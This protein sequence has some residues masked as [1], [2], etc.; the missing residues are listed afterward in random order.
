MAENDVQMIDEL[1]AR[2]DHFIWGNVLQK[3]GPPG[4]LAAAVLRYVYALLR[5]I[6]S[7]QLTLRAMSLVYTTLLSI[8]PLIA[9]SF[10]VLKGLGVHNDLR[11]ILDNLLLPLGDQGT[12]ISNQVFTL[13]DNVRG[14]ILGGVSLAFFIFTAISMVQKVEASFNYVWHVSKPRSFARRF[15]E[16]TIVLLIGPVVIVVALGMIASIQNNNLVQWLLTNESLGAVVL[17]VGKI[18]PYLLV[19][20]VFTFLYIFVPN[21][22]VRFKSALV[23][24]FAGGIIWASMSAVFATFVV[25]AGTRQLIY[26]GF[27]VAITALI[28][29][30]LNWLVLLVGAQLAFYHQR[31]AFLRIGQREPRLSN[32]MRERLALNSMYLVGRA[33]RHRDRSI[34]LD[35]IGRHLKIPVNALSQVTSRLAEAGLLISTE[36]GELLPGTEMSAMRLSDILRVVREVG[37][38]G[39]Y[40][41]PQ[42]TEGINELGGKLD[43]AIAGTIGEETLADLLASLDRKTPDRKK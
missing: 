40:R 32:A 25:Y 14:G 3:Y 9:F 4:Q 21:T 12:A 36:S 8:V 23:G 35:E 5:D 7:G 19:A 15:S 1:Q 28:W 41:E 11:P 13:V 18:V 30:Y 17:S 31:P 10:S 29:L 34:T 2:L 6:I 24:G 16:Y 38:T 43:A 37:D 20:A 39:S 26:S 27:A 42:W 33:Y 22:S